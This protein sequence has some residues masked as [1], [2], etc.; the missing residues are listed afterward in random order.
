MEFNQF[1]C[2]RNTK[3]DLTSPQNPQANGVAEI[4]IKSANR[5]TRITKRQQSNIP[6]TIKQLRPLDQMEIKRAVQRRDKEIP[7]TE[8]YEKIKIKTLDELTVG[9]KV[10][11]KHHKSGH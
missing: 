8:E 7:K 5:P 2:K 6:L 1:C 4:A 9:E 11:V 10:L 3:H